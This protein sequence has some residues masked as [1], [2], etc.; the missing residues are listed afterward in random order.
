[1]FKYAQ[2]FTFYTFYVE[3]LNFYNVDNNFF[4]KFVCI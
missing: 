1:M 2:C 3:S 4:F